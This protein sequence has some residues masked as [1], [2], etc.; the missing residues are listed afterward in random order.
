MLSVSNIQ[1]G[2]WEL[3]VNSQDKAG[4]ISSSTVNFE[5]VHDIKSP[6]SELKIEG[7]KF[8]IEGKTYITSS[9]LLSISA[10]DDLAETLDKKGFGVKEIFYSTEDSKFTAYHST[11]T[12]NDGIYSLKFYAVDIIGNVE[13][14]N[15]F[16]LYVDTTAPVTSVKIVRNSEYTDEIITSDDFI[17][18][19]SSDSGKMGCGV[20]RTD[21]RIYGGEYNNEW[22]KYIGPFNII[23]NDGTYTIEYYSVDNL[24]NTEKMNTKVFKLKNI[25]EINLEVS[26]KTSDSLTFG[27]VSTNVSSFTIH[28]TDGTLLSTLNRDSTFYVL[29]NLLPNTPYSVY[30][31]GYNRW[32]NKRTSLKTV[33]T[34]AKPIENLSFTNISKDTIQIYWDSDNPSGTEYCCEYS[35]DSSYNPTDFRVS[36]YEL[37]YVFHQLL[38]NTTYYFKVSA[39]NKDRIYTEPKLIST[40]T[41]ANVPEIESVYVIDETKLKVKI[42]PNSNPEWTKYKLVISTSDETTQELTPQ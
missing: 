1:S 22:H 33:Y 40:S 38:P 5:V 36:T 20:F 31:T 34:L 16:T 7:A 6:V 28:L 17:L 9:T 35:L 24:Y 26:T 19:E 11:F 25:P 14:V 15:T 21:Y 8:E 30:I 32:A 42:N 13:P 23:G 10:V 4:N 18:V 39:I 3:I 2:F 29:N 41:L 27:W 12:L 37:N